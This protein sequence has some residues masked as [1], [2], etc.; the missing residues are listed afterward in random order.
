MLFEIDKKLLL[1][2]LGDFNE[3]LCKSNL[4]ASISIYGGCAMMLHGYDSRRSVDLDG[5]FSE[6]TTGQVSDLLTKVVE[7]NKIERSFFDSSIGV[8][9]SKYLKTNEV[10]SYQSL[11]NLNINVCT[12]EQLLAMKLFSARLDS[13]RHDLEDAYALCVDLKVKERKELYQI[14]EKYILPE[15]I[16][17]QNN[18][19]KR[20]NC[21]DIFINFLLE[22]LKCLS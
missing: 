10:V 13:N 8:I 16:F 12:Q 20:K 22:R 9:I 3:E 6:I 11:S 14:L 15:E 17:F 21:I 5:V 1:K 4:F 18:S 19:P 2:I 7:K